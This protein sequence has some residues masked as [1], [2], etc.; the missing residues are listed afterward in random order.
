MDKTSQNQHK[1]DIGGGTAD[2]CTERS[3][4]RRH[5]PGAGA[6]SR[7]GSPG[8]VDGGRTFARELGEVFE[9]VVRQLFVAAV[10]D[11]DK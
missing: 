6:P 4:K 11:V 5:L 10:E 2:F 8:D 9:A 7:P 1:T 3:R